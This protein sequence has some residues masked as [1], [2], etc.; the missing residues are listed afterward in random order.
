MVDQIHYPKNS[1][2]ISPSLVELETILSH[3]ITISYFLNSIL[4]YYLLFH[5]FRVMGF[6]STTTRINV[7]FASHFVTFNALC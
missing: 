1:K 4:C 7:A 2:H 6:S 3:V 5:N